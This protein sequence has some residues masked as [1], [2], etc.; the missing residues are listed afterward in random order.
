[1]K[2]NSDDIWFFITNFDEFVN[3]ARSLVFKIFGESDSLTE[4]DLH[5]ILSS[6]EFEN[7][8]ELDRVLSFA[9]CA[10][11]VKAKAKITVDH[12]TKKKK[13]AINNSVLYE[14]L[15][16]M[17]SRMVSNI[18]HK[19]VSDNLLDSAFDSEKNDFIFWVKNEEN[20]KG[21]SKTS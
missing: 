19:L 5:G 8:E 20:N 2:N 7:Q 18:L 9:E 15:E 3:H 4:S 16:D 11:I 17:N 10:L 1:M 13:Y 21:E 12:K 14:I 6:V